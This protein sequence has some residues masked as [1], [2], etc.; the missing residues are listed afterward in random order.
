MPPPLDSSTD[1]WWAKDPVAGAPAGVAAAAPAKPAAAWWAND[2]VADARAS[3]GIRNPPAKTETL[4]PEAPGFLSTVG[5]AG[6]RGA[7]EAGTAAAQAPTAFQDRPAPTPDTSAVGRVLA[8]PVAEG[9]KSPTWWAAHIVHG[10]AASAP[11][12]AMGAAGAMGTQALFPEAPGVAALAGGAGGFALGSMISA[13]APAYQKARQDGLDHETAVKHA[14]AQTGIAGA[15]GALAGVL[16]G[17]SVFGRDAAGAIQRPIS[18]AL[19]QIFGVQPA[20]GAGQQIVSGGVEGKLPTPGELA[21]GY[22]ENAGMGAALVGAHAGYR[23]LRGVGAA[24]GAAPEAPP[25]PG[26]PPPPM[27]AS[28]ALEAVERV[29][30]GPVEEADAAARGELAAAAAKPAQSASPAPAP[31]PPEPVAPAPAS[32]DAAPPVEPAAPTRIRTIEQ[33][34]AEDGV[35]PRKAAQV[36]QAEIAA[37]GRPISEEERQARAAGVAAAGPKAVALPAT[38]PAQEPAGGFTMLRPDQVQR[39]PERFQYKSADDRGVTGALAGTTRWEPALA[40]PITAW[41]GRDG[42]LYVVNGHQRHDLAERAVAAG[43]PDVQIPARI[44]RAADGYTPEYMRALGAYQNIAQGSGTAIDAAKVLRGAGAI[45]ANMTLPELPPRQQMVRD[46]Q[47]LARLSDEAFGVVENGTVPAGY[48]A[49]VGERI[50]DPV[51]QL[52]ALD[53]LARAQPANAEQARI[54]VEDIRNSGF[55]RGNQTTLFGDQAFASSLVAERARVLENALRV[56][57]RTK[58]V[59]KAAVEGEAALTA[60]GN[61]LDREGNVAGQN[62]NE[63]LLDTLSRNATTRGPVSDALSAAARDLASGRPANT[64]VSRFLGAA[65]RLVADGKGDGLQPGVDTGGSGRPE[66]G[67]RVEDAGQVGISFGR[68]LPAPP[69][70]AGPD[71]LGQ[72]RRAPVAHSPEPSLRDD[73]RQVDMFGTAD[74]AVQAQAA[75]DAAGPRSGQKPADEGL[76]AGKEGEQRRMFGR[77][78]SPITAYHG[79]PHDFD[80][81]DISKIGTGEGAQAYGSGLYFAQNEGVAR[82][83]RDALSRGANA[84][85]AQLIRAEL[86]GHNIPAAHADALAG[87]ISAALDA[88]MNGTGRGPDWL[89]HVEDGIRNPSM[90][91]TKEQQAGAVE[92]LEKWK[93]RVLSPGHMY[94]V[95]LR[96]DPEHFL[97]WDKPLSEQSPYVRERLSD[98]LRFQKVP[99][100]NNVGGETTAGQ[101]MQ[102]LEDR[103][104]KAD[105]AN[106]LLSSGVPGIRYRDAGSRTPD[107][108]NLDGKPLDS[109]SAEKASIPASDQATLLRA[110]DHLQRSGLPEPKNAADAARM[111]RQQGNAGYADLFDKYADRLTPPERT[112]NY[113][114]LDDKLI[115]IERKY[116]R[117]LRGPASAATPHPAAVATALEA[118]TRIT[119]AHI[120]IELHPADSD[121]FTVQFPNGRT[122]RV[123]GYAVGRL[124]RAAIEP[125]NI[126]AHNLNHEA[127]H[128]LVTLGVFKPGEWRTLTNAAERGDW[129]GHHNIEKRYPDLPRERQ[130]E[131]SIAEEF[132]HWTRA[133]RPAPPLIQRMLDRLRQFFERLRNALAGRGFRTVEDV[134]GRAERGEVGRREP[135][136]DAPT[137][138]ASQEEMRQFDVEQGR[139]VAFGRRP[140]GQGELPTPEPI[141]S[142]DDFRTKVENIPRIGAHLAALSDHLTDFGHTVQMMLTPMAHG[143][144][145]ARAI[146][147]D[148]A[149]ARRFARDEGGQIVKWL[150]SEFKPAEL[151][152]MWNRADAESVARQNGEDPTGRG[153]DM[154]PPR[155]REVVQQ[156]QDSATKSLAAAKKLGMFEGDGLPSYVPRMVTG[157]GTEDTHVVRDIRTLAIATTKLQEAIAGR[158]L[159]EGIRQAGMQSGMATVRD[160]SM[161]GSP[162]N[163]FGNNLRTST[164]QLRQRKYLTTEETEAAARRIPGDDEG[165]RWFTVKEN[166]AFWTSRVTGTDAEGKPNWERVPVYVR[167]D[168]E[169]PL[170]AVLTKPD[171]MIHRG[172]MDLKGRMMTSIMYGVAHLGVIIGRA[173]PASPR[174][175]RTMREGY[176][177]KQD[178]AIRRRAILAGL[179][180]IGDRFAGVGDIG[181]LEKD[182]ALSAGRSWTAQLLAVVPGLFDPRAGLAVKR[183]IDRLGDFTHNTLLWNRV[184]DIQ[185]GLFTGFERH[186]IEKGADPQSAARAAAHFANRYAGALP[187]EAMSQNAR[188]IANFALFSRTYRLG[189]FG[190]MKDALNGIP[191][192]VQAQI[193]RDKGAA[194]LENVRGAAQRKAIATL[195]FD[196]ALYYA[197]NSLIQSGLNVLL[198]DSTLDEEAKGYARRLLDEAMKIGSNPLQALNPFGVLQSLTPMFEHEPEKQNR[199]LIGYEKD[200][201]GIYLRNPFGKYAEDIT[202]YWTQPLKTLHSMMSPFMRPLSAVWSNDAGFGRKIYDPQADT[203]AKVA[204]NIRDVLLDAVEGATPRTAMRAAGKLMSGEGGAF[205]AAQ[206]AGGGLGFSLSHGYPGGPARGEMAMVQDQARF[207]QGKAMPAIRAKIKAGDVDGAIADMTAL[208][209]PPSMMRFEIVQ[210]RN[211]HS[212]PRQAQQFMRTATP[213]QREAL[214]RMQRRMP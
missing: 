23:G 30:A 48:A 204:G 108:W 11:A 104:G 182:P 34:Q 68:H 101:M 135:A 116:N 17:L 89:R 190:A 175:I 96:A 114:V 18:E 25:A 174:I 64:V 201:T 133:E 110:M 103:L 76:F 107:V 123:F 98:V 54:M 121:V 79:S 70:A 197:G 179:V 170:R 20:V 22:A 106:E 158:R 88:H 77:G 53:V 3:S 93:K 153:L 136:A 28:T 202:D 161:P 10:A 92:V 109:R 176:V 138:R 141:K 167:S 125:G 154:L 14:I 66:E 166:P 130:I 192:D 6:L 213:E 137:M 73:K 157:I 117:Q 42:G 61:K 100:K 145:Q 205:E 164:P 33:I 97:D 60:V 75:R 199:I 183:G 112:H 50:S 51:E 143:T 208:G 12:L 211:P 127:L 180:P 200:G 163:P 91:L 156:L 203:P 191:R 171:G 128:A 186:L 195:A 132:A 162:L 149:N 8:T 207:A 62:E 181:N 196:M 27:P 59:F 19:L 146:A 57:R 129:I 105:A 131:E 144:D 126:T 78:V 56:L 44:F 65:R 81:F 87:G 29:G 173:L 55:L 13:I 94:E 134:F 188:K 198:G 99:S 187:N 1:Q 142:A 111:L 210:T 151:K 72:E 169:G 209:M 82:S 119:G 63:R 155:Q 24:P 36:Q 58:G 21:T 40:D 41:Q 80:R 9:W 52:A 5:Q 43:Q 189:N 67:G 214:E 47:A 46:G 49:R 86:K 45:P 26:A 206:I 38:A 168:F 178:P 31:A 124:I 84:A 120:K 185:F 194:A 160:G 122:E 39:D 118:A 159:I 148:F 150:G 95:N 184:A 140:T 15:A 193:L 35:S 69:P 177:A 32:V 90:G 165:F 212:T 172:A 4:P 71:L 74:A 152:K 102:Y 139:V 147:K 37:M 2:P 85:P 115:D 16:P 83:Y 113:V 7:I